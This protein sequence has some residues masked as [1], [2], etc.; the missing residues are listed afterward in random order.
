MSALLF[1]TANEFTVAQGQKGPILCHGIKGFS[2]ILFY[3]T[4]CEYCKHLIPVF[5][6]LPGTVYGC[7]FGMINVSQNKQCVNMAAQTVAPIKYVPYIVLYNNGRPFY[8]YK[9][10]HTPKDIAHFVTDVAKRLQTRQQ[11][12][13]ENVKDTSRPIPKYTIG[14][15]LY[16]D[17]DDNV[18]YLDFQTAYPDKKPQSMR[19]A[20]GMQQQQGGYNQGMQQQQGGGGYNQPAGMQHMQQMQQMHNMQQASGMHQQPY[21]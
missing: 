8:E 9:G 14:K 5:K 10:P 3:S 12:A 6:S 21:I 7:Q 16:G 20:P 4:Q 19:T 15:P 1:L 2:L 18:C 11:P 13:Q 17:G